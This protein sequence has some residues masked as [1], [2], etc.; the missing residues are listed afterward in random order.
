MEAYKYGRL[1]DVKT[2][3]NEL[4]TNPS[5]VINVQDEYG[6]SHLHI[7][8]FYGNTEIAEILLKHNAP[9]DLPNNNGNSP[10]HIAAMFGE[11]EM[12]EILLK[13]NAPL[14]MKNNAGKTPSQVAKEKRCPCGTVLDL[15][16]FCDRDCDRKFYSRTTCC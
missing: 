6:N 5:S 16:C 9:L 15:Q 14:E 2:T 13:N 11:I 3:L 8:A 12:T 1:L 7:A 10:L 4:K